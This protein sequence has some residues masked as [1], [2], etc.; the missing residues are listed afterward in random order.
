[1]AAVRAIR[2]DA[3]RHDVMSDMRVKFWGVRGSL[4]TPGAGTLVYGGNTACVEIRCGG[5][6]VI[7]DA[8]SGLRELGRVI[9][10]E[11][12]ASDLDLLLTHC[13]IDHIMGLPFF[14]PA[15]LPS[16]TLRLWAGHLSEREHLAEVVAQLMIPPLLPITP[17]MFRA[18]I[19][20]HDFLAGDGFDLG[21]GVTV[22]TAPLNHPGGATGYRVTFADHAVCYFTDHEHGVDGPDPALVALARGADLL[23]YDATFTADEYRR[24]AGWGHSTWAEGAKLADAA[25]VARLVLF[26][27]APERADAAL[28]EIERQAAAARPGTFAAKEGTEIVLEGALEDARQPGTKHDALKRAASGAQPLP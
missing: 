17:Q 6:R 5:R 23:I 10:A 12:E 19:D 24:C 13:H 2:P 18:R 14:A 11:G 7:L 25:G 8:G 28:A 1:M 3:E 15:F 22:R 21:G 9:A 20:Y 16:S 26:H 27:H 4:P